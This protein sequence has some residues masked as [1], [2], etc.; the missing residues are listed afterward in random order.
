MFGSLLEQDQ[1]YFPSPT[2]SR[3]NGFPVQNPLIGDW[4][5][6]FGVSQ[7]EIW[8]TGDDGSA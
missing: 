6:F 2:E 7:F 3:R 8:E 5:L 1:D 4:L